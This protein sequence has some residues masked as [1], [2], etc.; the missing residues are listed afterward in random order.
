MSL[1]VAITLPAIIAI[2][3]LGAARV[4]SAEVDAFLRFIDRY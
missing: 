4:W 1:L 2:G 3:V